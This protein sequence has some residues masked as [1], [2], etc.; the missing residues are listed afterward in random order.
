MKK[1][2][3]ISILCVIFISFGNVANAETRMNITSTE[4]IIEDGMSGVI[5]NVDV[6]KDAEQMII[7]DF[8]D[9][10]GNVIDMDNKMTFEIC[11]EDGSV[12]ELEEEYIKEDTV[13]IWGG[14]WKDDN[15]K[16]WCKFIFNI[17]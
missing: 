4:E 15:N 3:I 16:E 6:I 14:L 5:V 11:H 13:I 10:V 8:L 12:I 17:Q 9:C 1:K 7:L 2:I